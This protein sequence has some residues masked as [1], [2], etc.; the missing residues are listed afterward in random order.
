MA[1][2]LGLHVHNPSS[3]LKPFELEMRR[4]L[5]H[6]ICV[7]DINSSIDRGTEPII[8][9]RFTTALTPLNVNDTD[10]FPD[11]DALPPPRDDFTDVSFCLMG[12][13]EKSFIWSLVTVPRDGSADDLPQMSW[14]QKQEGTFCQSY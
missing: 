7:L 6:Q 1:E 3:S 2:A 8:A 14:Q 4:R 5:W 13:V 9:K 10:L 12:N 11:M